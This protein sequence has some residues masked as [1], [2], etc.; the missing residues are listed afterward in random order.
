MGQNLRLGSSG[1]DVTRVQQALNQR[2]LPPN[3][4]ITAPPM[5]RLAEDSKFGPKTAAMVMEFQRLNRIDID[6]VVGRDTYYLLFP[7]I[8]FTAEMAG[9]GLIRGT[10]HG[11]PHLRSGVP[12]RAMARPARVTC[13]V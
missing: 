9:V 12:I 3:N 8:A 11:A 6:G 4:R 2:M 1:P 10:R 7:Y 13:R 5:E